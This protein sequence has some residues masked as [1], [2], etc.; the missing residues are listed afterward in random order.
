MHASWQATSPIEKVCVLCE[1]LSF[2]LWRRKISTESMHGSVI[3][4]RSSS[5]GCLNR[6]KRKLFKKL[7]RNFSKRAERPLSW[8]AERGKRLLPFGRQK[9]RNQRQYWYWCPLW[10]FS[11]RR[12]PTGA[13]NPNGVIAFG[14]YAFVLI[15]PWINLSG[16]TTTRLSNQT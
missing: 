15:Q 1:P 16:T 5:T 3:K 11:R 6:T 2:T 9:H 7:L 14:I 10:R 4:K 13:S 8:P 12:C